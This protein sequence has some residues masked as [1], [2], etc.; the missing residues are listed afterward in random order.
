MVRRYLMTYGSQLDGAILMGTGSQPPALLSAAKTTANSLSI[1]RGE[2]HRSQL[3]MKMAFGSYNKQYPSVRT[4]YDWL[5]RNEANV[6]TYLA[7]PYCGF[8]FTLNGYKV[9]F[10]VLSFI[11]E[12]AHISK[13]PKE[14]P[15]YLW[16]EVMILWDISVRTCRR[17]AELTVRQ[18]L[19][20]SK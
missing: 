16:R 3:M 12:P 4:E 1:V 13:L 10:D 8:M 20:M 17:F 15:L 2:R 9:L 5:S 14:V 11:Q 7:D 6:D 18:G 19:R